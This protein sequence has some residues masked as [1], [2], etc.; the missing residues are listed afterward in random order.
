ME[1]QNGLLIVEEFHFKRI[2]TGFLT[3]GTKIDIGGT[4]EKY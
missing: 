4:M 2:K 3:G 1:R